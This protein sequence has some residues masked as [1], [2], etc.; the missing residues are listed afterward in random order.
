M[1]GQPKWRREEYRTMRAKGILWCSACKQW[2]L[3][4][5]F[6]KLSTRPTGFQGYCKLCS[7]KYSSRYYPK[8]RE[9]HREVAKLSLQTSMVKAAPAKLDAG[10]DIALKVQTLC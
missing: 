7:A 5:N 4:E 1:T 3:K 10:T 2:K 9:R 8:H 6:N